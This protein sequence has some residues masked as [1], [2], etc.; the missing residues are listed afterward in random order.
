MAGMYS[1]LQMLLLTSLGCIHCKVV[2]R[3]IDPPEEVVI[4]DP[5][6]L[7]NLEITWSPSQQFARISQEEQ[8]SLLY[9]L[10]YYATYSDRWTR[11]RT[12]QTSFS[13]Q[14]DL[15]QE[16]KVRVYT[17]ITG[18][19]VDG[20]TVKSQDY[21]E[22]VQNPDVT[23]THGIQELACVN[24]N[25]E[26]MICNWTRSPKMPR[27]AQETLFYWH[28]ELAHAEECPQYII[29]NGI[30][31]GCNFSG[32]YIPTFSD[33]NLCVNASSSEEHIKPVYTSLQ[34][35]NHVKP[36]ATPKINVVMGPDRQLRLSWDCPSGRIPEHCLEWQVEDMRGGHDGKQAL[37]TPTETAV[38]LTLP[39]KETCC[40]K[41]RSRLSKYC[42]SRSLWSDWSPPVCYPEDNPL[43][44]SPGRDLSPTFV[45]ITITIIAALV[46][47]LCGWARLSLRRSRP[48]KKT[49]PSFPT[50]FYQK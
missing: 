3:S 1:F 25:M 23:G 48:V 14:F 21:T 24:Y 8:C 32:T 11:I 9:E 2:S 33:V 42:A 38:N 37:I 28:K 12:S 36:K 18:A 30:R 34:T 15:A 7:G 13:A 10:H 5:G 39:E 43:T 19:C 22:V 26:H 47:G 17:L 40:L 16:V 4:T 27:R 46:L 20:G 49:D 44:S 41:V 50:P 31:S 29:S 35:Q 6:R 45:F